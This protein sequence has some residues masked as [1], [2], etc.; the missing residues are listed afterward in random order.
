MGTGSRGP[1]L[2]QRERDQFV[3]GIGV[4][5][6][7]DEPRHVGRHESL[8]I[9]RQTAGVIEQ[10]TDGHRLGQKTGKHVVDGCLQGQFPLVDQLQNN[11][12]H[13][14]FGDT[15]DSQRILGGRG[16]V[17]PAF[18]D[19]RRAFPLTVAVPKGDDR[20]RRS[21]AHQLV[22]DG[23]GVGSANGSWIGGCRRALLSRTRDKHKGSCKGEYCRAKVHTSD[24][25]GGLR[26]T[27]KNAS[28]EVTR[29]EFP[30]AGEPSGMVRVSSR[31]MRVAN[32]RATADRSVAQH[33]SS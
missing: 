33:V 20:G 31:P 11:G 32:P 25:T 2:C 22:D 3:V 18:D 29:S 28:A 6:G 19:A 10:L 15:G 24:I 9:V 17:G 7:R 14:G 30:V 5:G 16:L 4:V 13:H 27:R 1:R 26:Q 12:R 21:G 8:E 23:L